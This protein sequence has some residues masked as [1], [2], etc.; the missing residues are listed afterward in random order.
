MHL[1]PS[2]TA[3]SDRS[4]G[5]LGIIPVGVK[6]VGHS[7]RTKKGSFKPPREG[8]PMPTGFYQQARNRVKRLLQLGKPI[9]VNRRR[10][11]AKPTSTKC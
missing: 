6:R 5:P 11:V 1:G 4:G 8:V 10:T 3:G 2:A 7:L 9:L